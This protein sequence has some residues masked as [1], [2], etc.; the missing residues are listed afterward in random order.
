MQAG[1][2]SCVDNLNGKSLHDKN[3]EYQK[4]SYSNVDSFWEKRS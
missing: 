3:A 2:N 4:W 1:F